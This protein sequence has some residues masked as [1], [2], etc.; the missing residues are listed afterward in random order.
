[1]A[2]LGAF[3][4]RLL[5]DRGGNTA[6]MQQSAAPTPTWRRWPLPAVTA[7]LL[8]WALHRALLPFAGP[9]AAVT[10]AVLLGLVLA[11]FQAGRWRALIVAGGFPLML[12]LS[13]LPPW[14]GLPLVALGLMIYPPRAWRD[15]P[16]FPTPAGALDGLAAHILLPP[17]ARLLDAGCG[18][19]HGLRALQRA[20]PQALVEGIEWSRP[21][22]LW[23][24]WRHPRA[25]VCR[26]DLWADGAWRGL[27]LVYLFQ[28]P[29]S[30]ARAWD[31][32]RAEMAPGTWLVS[33]EF[34]LPGRAAD[35]RVELPGGRPV[36]AWRIPAP[37]SAPGTADNPR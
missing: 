9:A 24:R 19:G 14:A 26:G 37:Q 15:A 35:I 16:V 6:A 8:A 32:A 20:W 34:E 36:W 13:A 28:R 27:T 23:S 25:R 7:W 5:F 33:L 31:K 17:G 10:M 18:A 12:L 11:K 22:A 4:R 3:V 21:L 29:E 1:M 30:M 2:G